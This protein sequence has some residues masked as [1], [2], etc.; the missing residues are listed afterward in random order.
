MRV[1]ACRLS[2]A[3][4]AE[5]WLRAD[6]PAGDTA[7]RDRHQVGDPPPEPLVSHPTQPVD[8]TVSF[9]SANVFALGVMGAT[10]ALVLP[11]HAVIWGATADVIL[12]AL[13]DHPLL[14][15]L[16]V[17]VASIV[18]H[19]LLHAWGF[20]YLGKVPWSGIRMGVMWRCLTPYASTREP[21]SAHAYRWAAALPGIVLGLLPLLAG[22]ATG[23]ALLTGYGVMM[24]AAAGGDHAALWAM[25]ALPGDTTVV[26]SAHRVGCLVLAEPTGTAAAEAGDLAT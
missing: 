17:M 14:P 13:F 8:R 3:P 19:E 26:D 20:H 7:V 11:L 23:S 2:C 16:L 24:F 21:V 4:G 1:R 10:V 5:R 15:M 25:R 18:V 6:L 22:L 9:I 12:E